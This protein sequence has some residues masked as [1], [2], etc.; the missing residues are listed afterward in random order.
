MKNSEKE[1]L[2]V[3]QLQAIVAHFNAGFESWRAEHGMVANFGWSYTRND[4][5]EEAP[6]VLQLYS[7]DRIIFRKPPPSPDFLRA[8]LNEMS[9]GA[10]D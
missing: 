8:R 4:Q 9:E 1:D 6:K 2:A 5:G 3:A 7:V 10:E